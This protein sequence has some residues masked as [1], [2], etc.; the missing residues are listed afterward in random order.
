MKTWEEILGILG[1]KL[2]FLGD[3]TIIPAVLITMALIILVSILASRLL[4]RMLRR[5]HI[6]EG[7]KEARGLI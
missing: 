3:V 6:K 1:K 2:V 4:Q 7:A 5:M